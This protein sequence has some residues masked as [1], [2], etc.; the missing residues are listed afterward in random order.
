MAESEREEAKT[1]NRGSYLIVFEPAGLRGLQA[2][3]PAG[4]VG[5][6]PRWAGEG[7]GSPLKQ[8]TKQKQVSHKEVMIKKLLS[9][10]ICAESTQKSIVIFL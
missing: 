6:A 10:N 4:S 8:G 7:R 1:I 3:S 2:S 5:F 9:D